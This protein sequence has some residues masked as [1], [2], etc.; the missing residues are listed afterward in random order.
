MLITGHQ[1]VQARLHTSDHRSEVEPS[2]SDQP[3]CRSRDPVQP[4]DLNTLLPLLSCC[5]DPDP[6]RSRD[7]DLLREL[8]GK[9][10]GLL[11]QGGPSR[12]PAG[13]SANIESY[14]LQT[15]GGERERNLIITKLS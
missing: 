3:D 12:E 7:W 10:G 15:P 5:S 14:F 1:E 9:E 2:F 11:F 6:L 8:Q 13:T 4:G